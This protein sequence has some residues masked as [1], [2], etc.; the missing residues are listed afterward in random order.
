MLRCRG[1]A[2][3]DSPPGR[4]CLLAKTINK[5]S[6]ISLSARIRSSSSRASSIRSRSPESITNIK[7]CNE[8]NVGDGATS[9]KDGPEFRYSNVAKEVG[10]YLVHRH[11]VGHASIS[12]TSHEYVGGR[13]DLFPVGKQGGLTQTLNLT[14]LYVTVS[15]LNPTVGIVVTDWLSLS[16]Y[17]IAERVRSAQLVRSFVHAGERRIARGMQ[18]T[19]LSRCVQA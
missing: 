5:Q 3:A 6:R 17:R 1:R 2:E 14:F 9:G 15:T 7:P 12:L 8:I 13:R 19:C 4:S 11:P 18:R 16:L 10:S